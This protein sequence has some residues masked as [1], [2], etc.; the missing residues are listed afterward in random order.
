MFTTVSIGPAKKRYLVNSLSTPIMAPTSS[1][2]DLQASKQGVALRATIPFIVFAIIAI[3][4]RF[5][6]R[7]IQPSRYEF[8]DYIIV[9]AL[10]FTLG[11]FALSMEVVHFGSGKHLAAV[12]ITEIAQFWKVRPPSE[13][14]DRRSPVTQME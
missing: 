3:V 4:C 11:T 5:I 6:S 7:T 9:V 1:N 2:V 13:I 8:D 12:P 10:I 14:E